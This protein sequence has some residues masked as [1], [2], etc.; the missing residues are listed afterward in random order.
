MFS[1]LIVDDAFDIRMGLKNYFPWKDL[2]FDPVFDAE[3][4]ADA[5]KIIKEEKVD[6][7]M[8]DLMMPVMGGIE[9]VRRALMINAKIVPVLLSGFRDFDAAKEALALGVREYLLKPVGYEELKEIFT[10]ISD[11]LSGSITLSGKNAL[12][13]AITYINNHLDTVSLK[14]LSSY[15]SLNQFYLSALFHQEIGVKFSDYVLS[16][17]MERAMEMLATGMAIQ[18]IA[19][20]VGYTNPSSFTRAF[21]LYYGKS[22]KEIR[23]GRK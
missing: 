10:R 11:E 15:L 13:N 8:T 20:A 14:S 19:T 5:L 6:V 2:G 21:R 16:H 12:D 3:S 9:L 1:L 17:R 4:G 18:E 7:L 22:P 23:S